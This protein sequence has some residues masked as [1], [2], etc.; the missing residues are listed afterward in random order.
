MTHIRLMSDLHLE[1]GPLALHGGVEDV[2]V[3]AGD[4]GI[5][6]DGIVW[7]EKQSH[8][9]GIPVVMIAGN[10]EFYQNTRHRGHSIVSTLD[11]L[12]ETAAKTSGCVTFLERETATISGVRFIGA[13]LWTDFNLFGNVARA[14]Y[15]AKQGMNDYRLIDSSKA[16]E[17]HPDV[18]EREHMLSLAYIKNELDKPFPGKTVVMTHHAP[19]R[20]SIAGRYARDEYSPAY[21][22]NLDALVE[23]SGAALWTHGHVHFTF[24]YMVGKT[25]V[26]T[27]PRGY[28]GYELNPDFDPSLTIDLNAMAA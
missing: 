24:K 6:T 2:L 13:T 5:F 3:L 4:I 9:L 20:R 1:F 15:A 21:A 10:H 8:E 23:K 18:A 7:A 19:S 14:K 26:Q 11:A 16:E 27:N 12:H 17:F 22:S 28:Y 25:L